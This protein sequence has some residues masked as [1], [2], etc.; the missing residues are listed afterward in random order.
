MASRNRCQEDQPVAGML[1]TEEALGGVY[2][3]I[4]KAA[5]EVSEGKF[6]HKDKWLT[7]KIK[8]KAVTLSCANKR[9]ACKEL[10]TLPTYN[11]VTFHICRGLLPLYRFLK[12]REDQKRPMPRKVS[13]SRKVGR[14]L[15]KLQPNQGGNEY[16]YLQYTENGRSTQV[17]LGKEKPKFDPKVDLARAKLKKTRKIRRPTAVAA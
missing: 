11:G 2:R 3:F 1:L 12:K 9:Q 10:Q 15:Y 13:A 4:S 5:E 14:Y 17:Y 7:V 16:W 8:K 6:T